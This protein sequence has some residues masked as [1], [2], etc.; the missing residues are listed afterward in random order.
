MMEPLTQQQAK[1][2]GKLRLKKFRDEQ[3]CMLLEGERL[4]T[5]ALRS[6]AALRMVIV[7]RGKEDRYAALLD[8]A[9]ARGSELRI[10]AP[11][12]FERMADTRSPQGIAAVA[13]LP[14]LDP[15]SAL[16]QADDRLP[17]FALHGVTDP[18]NLGTIIR[19]TAWFGGN[20]LL[21]SADSVDP[22][23]PKV[24]RG[25]MGAIFNVRIGQYPSAAWLIDAA[26]RSNRRLAVTSAEGGT[27]PGEV[28]HSSSILAVLGNEAYGVPEELMEASGMRVTIPGGGTESLNLSISHAILQFSWSTQKG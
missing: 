10:A 26:E 17:L 13:E 6:P 19:S 23:S 22:F 20:T 28:A 12:L 2:F 16:E 15:E 7:E 1:D 11:K 9:E 3:Q 4:V 18:G 21:L 14:T 25:S 5:D 24:V 8:S 27:A